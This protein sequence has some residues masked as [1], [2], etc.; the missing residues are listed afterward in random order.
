MLKKLGRNTRVL[1]ALEPLLLF[2]L[3]ANDMTFL[4]RGSPGSVTMSKFCNWEGVLLSL[5]GISV[6]DDVIRKGEFEWC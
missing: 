2:K 3:L 5:Y 4:V 6:I 1:F